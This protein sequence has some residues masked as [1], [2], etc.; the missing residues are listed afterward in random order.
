MLESSDKDIKAIL[1]KYANRF[2]IHE[3]KKSQ[4]SKSQQTNMF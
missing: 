4:K 2:E 1:I 3:K